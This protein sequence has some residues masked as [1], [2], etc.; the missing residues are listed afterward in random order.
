MDFLK[1]TN[2][3]DLVRKLLITILSLFENYNSEFN[4][5]K[6]IDLENISEYER[7]VLIKT[8]KEVV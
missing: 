3:R 6:V 4:L 1:V 8:L 5:A 2:N 7:E